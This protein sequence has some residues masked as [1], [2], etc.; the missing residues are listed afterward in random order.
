M[1]K[2]L[3]K[4]RDRPTIG[5]VYVGRPTRWGNPFAI[6]K[7]G[8]RE[9]VIEKYKGWL[10]CQPGLIRAAK[11]ELKGKDLICFCA[12]KECH[13]DILLEISNASETEEEG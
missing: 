7:D 4:H 6:G 13:A 8:T 10:L 1:P 5:S 11:R 12:P 3:N 2:V 9:E